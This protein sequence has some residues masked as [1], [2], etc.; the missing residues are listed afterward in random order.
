MHAFLASIPLHDVRV[1]VAGCGDMARAKL[2]LFDGS[3]ATVDWFAPG[4]AGAIDRWPSEAD[5][6]GARLVFIA[7]DDADH[8]A[9]LANAARAA[10][11][12]V[13]VVDRPALSDFHTP[14]LIDREGVVVGVATAGVA[15]VLA[16]EVRARVEAALPQGLDRLAKLS[17]E[18]RET[19]LKTVPDFMARRRFWERAFRGPARD[20]ALEGRT[21]EARRAMLALLNTS[22]PEPGVVHIVGA[23]PGD[24]ELLT[25]K[26]VRALEDADVVIHDRLVPDAIL[27]RARRDAR[28]LYVGKAKGEHSVPQD[29][30]EALMIAE[31]R[32]GHRVVRLKGGDPFVFGRGGEELKAVR[33]AGIEVIVVPGITAALGCA[34]AAGLPLT[35]RDYAQ[36]VSFVTAQGK[37]DGAAADWTALAAPNHTVVI[38]MGVDRAEQVQA[39]LLAGGRDPETPV[40]VIENGSRPD[41]RVLTGRLS[42]LGRVVREGAVTGPALLIVGE[43]AAWAQGEGLAEPTTVAAREL[44]EAAA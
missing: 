34:A 36:A 21:A 8:A 38:Y 23:G 16:R 24:P 15:P 35:H 42:A 40:A 44:A 30:I 13:N 28:R 26:A 5:L 12:Q 31:A 27:N 10:G 37:K 7:V 25:L 22:K 14:A 9:Q 11:A 2:R 19:V 43:T 29:E 39:D 20:L 33:D 3:P 1:V 6:S 4:E 41:Q 17:A 32:E 18:I